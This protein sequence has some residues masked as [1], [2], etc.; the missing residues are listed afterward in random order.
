[1]FFRAGSPVL[2]VL[3]LGLDLFLHFIMASSSSPLSIDIRC[4]GFPAGTLGPDV[5]KWLVDFFLAE[6][7]HKIVAVQELPGKVA[8]VTFGEGG[9][10]HKAH[11]LSAGKVLI[12][13]IECVVVRPPPPPPS[14]T[15]VVVHQFPFE[16]DN[17]VLVKELSAFGEVKDI[18]FQKWTNIP[19]VATGTRL[20]RMVR[21]KDIPRFLSV[22][23][24]RVKV[25]YKGQPVICDIC[26]KEGHRAAACPLKGKCLRCHEVG[27]FSRDCLRP[28]GSFSGPSAAR[29]SAAG[30]SSSASA[31]APV[32]ERHPHEG[33]DAPDV[34]YAEDLDRGFNESAGDDGV[35]ADAASVAEAVVRADDAGTASGDLTPEVVVIDEGD[36]SPSLLSSFSLDVR[37]NQLDELDSQLSQSIL[38]NCGLDGVSSGGELVNSQINMVCNVS[39]VSNE[40][41]KENGKESEIISN[42]SENNSIVNYYGSSVPSGDT[43]PG[44]SSEVS[45]AP[46]DSEM[47]QVSDQCKRP[48][49]EVISDDAGSDS[50][51]RSAAPPTR[52]SRVAAL[53]RPL[54]SKVKKPKK[55]GSV[56]GHVPGGVVSAARLSRG[57]T[58]R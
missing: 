53:P 45:V 6:T 37:D 7:G 54:V 9:E 44:P 26:R 52:A 21:T 50:V 51:P 17:D 39:N 3:G 33:N 35:L 36:S 4:E 58:K 5:A 28:W 10:A 12:H 48:I 34:Y 38:P 19:D 40:V 30:S 55:S 25:W 29:Q 24:V 43:P 46:V 14:Y 15:T 16:G 41:K 49:S 13:G 57:T 23:G 1:M 32:A 42:N 22:L 2:G 27:H 56:P 11:F 8:R 20:V 47:T 31:A 18:R